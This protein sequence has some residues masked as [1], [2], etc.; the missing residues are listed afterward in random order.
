M[1]VFPFSQ[2]D[3]QFITTYTLKICLALDEGDDSQSVLH[4]SA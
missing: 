3:L 2:I 1:D 4:L